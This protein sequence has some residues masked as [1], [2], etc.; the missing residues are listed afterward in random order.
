M[1]LTDNNLE[2]DIERFTMSGEI[3]RR[4]VWRC[5]LLG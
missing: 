5:G 4:I 3:A 1:W 2:A